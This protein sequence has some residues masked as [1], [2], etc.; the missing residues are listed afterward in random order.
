MRNIC[1]SFLQTFTL[2]LI[3][4]FLSQGKIFSQTP[5][6]Q[7][8]L[9]AIPVCDYVYEEDSTAAGYGN[10]FEIPNGGNNCPNHCMDGEKN[11]RWYVFTVVASGNLRFQIT[12]QTQTDDYDWAV[13]N[14]SEY[15]CQDI[16]A[17]PD[18]LMS[19]CNAAGGAGYQGTTGI[20]S[21]NGGNSSCNNGGNTNKWNADLPVYEGET[22]VLVVSDWTQTPGGYTLNFTPSTAVIFDDQQP[23]I[24][25]IG[26]DLIE[27]CGT[28]E[29]F[30][31]FS[32]NIKCSSINPGD[33][34]LHGPG[35][36]YDI[37]SIY[38][39][40]CEIGGTYEREYTL[41]FSP[42]IY[43]GG[44]YTL[45]INNLS[46]ISDACNNYAAP[47]DYDFEI[48][49]NAPDADAGDDIDIAYAATATLDGD[50]SG[51]SGDYS[52][53]W[54]PADMLDNPNIP[55][56]TTVNLTASTQFILT[57]NDEVS[58]C[59]GEDTM[60]V[61]IVGGPL[62]VTLSASS[63]VICQSEIVNLYAYPDGGSGDY[64][65]TWTSD[66]EGFN[67]TVQNP[68]DFPDVTTT[69]KLEITDGYTTINADITITVNPKP[70]SNAGIDQTINIGTSTN[71]AGTGSGGTGNY[72]YHWE[73]NSFLQ[74]NNVPNPLTTILY[75][76]VIF[77]MVVED[78]N[79]C[80]SEPDNV[81]VNTEGPAISA[82]PLADPPVICLGD[83]TTVAANATGGGGEFVY[84]WTSS[85][86]G[87]TSSQASFTD[88]PEET[89]RYDLL[90]SDQYDSE[91]S[92]HVTVT[93]NALPVVDLVPDNIAPIGKDTIAVCVRDSVLL[94]AGFDDDPLGSIYFWNDNYEGRYFKAVT[95]GNWL[96][97]QTHS[98]QVEDGV[99]KCK[100]TGNI[101]IL[102][103]FNECEIGVPETSVDLYSAV[104]L[105]PNPN[106]GR[107]ILSFNEDV[108]DLEVTILDISGRSVFHQ[109]LIGRTDAGSQVSIHSNDLEKGLYFVR[110]SSGNTMIVKQ[111]IVN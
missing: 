39:A 31:R 110:L 36:P 51:G 106:N 97:W 65:F 77:T 22:Y 52:F 108:S 68:S 95:N 1:Q 50:A 48:D 74:E 56:P 87:F 17:H 12:P 75:D 93:V 79:A 98:V 81:L 45:E 62:G 109:Q 24:E 29:V 72:I 5:T 28:N 86:P 11:S 21:S 15:K 8:C 96:D 42:A 85:P 18:W 63:T 59:V 41:Y 111:M 66:P 105:H 16:Y 90:V 9:G 83:E 78:E 20:S 102:F 4:L 60:W 70:T 61:N 67:S 46:F 92:G 76:P 91:F 88:S 49:L 23:F 40:N 32:E 10:Y 27:D 89:T 25:Y 100:N 104:E 3:F 26:G 30:V 57:V 53:H 19:S 35:G 80:E 44:D 94:D 84:Q 99:T 37:D 34:E 82:L 13:F 33:F 69:Y 107:F 103:D 6:T 47:D 2:S 7:D 55:N 54:E 38:G 73:P 43:Q 71:L 58:S 64:S 14:L 101:T